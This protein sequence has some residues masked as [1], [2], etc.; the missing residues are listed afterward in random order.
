MQIRFTNILTVLIVLLMVAPQLSAKG[1]KWAPS[2]STSLTETETAFIVFM[3]EEEKLAR[4][5]Y[6]T[7]G[8]FW[9][10]AVF[11]NI[12]TSEQQHMDSME[13]LLD[14][15]GITDPVPDESNIGSFENDELSALYPVLISSGEQSQYDALMVGALIEEVD[16]E[17]IQLAIDATK[18]SDIKAVYESLLCGSRNHLRAYVAQIE[19][20][21]EVYESQLDPDDS[22]WV[23]FI[24]S[25]IDSPMER[26]CGSRRR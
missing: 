4:D 2:G 10:M 21:G 7:L 26:S 14:K 24:D 19:S 12:A 3:R 5:V 6:I 23:S 11:D 20:D 16:M 8:D 18:R 17:D 13:T 22:E 25:I 15:Y 9:S 1:G